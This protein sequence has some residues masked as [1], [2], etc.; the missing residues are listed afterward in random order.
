M[1]GFILINVYSKNEEYLYQAKR[2]QEEFAIKGVSV[3]IIEGGNFLLYIE[4][5]NIESKINEYDF[6]V[7]WDKDKYLL[8]ML[9]KINMPTFNSCDA[10]LTCSDKMLTHIALANKGIPMP[11]TYAGLLCYNKEQDIKPETL[12]F[13]ETL[14]YPLVVKDSYGALGKGVYLAKNRE[15][16]YS[17]MNLVK[18]RAHLFQE[19][20]ETSYGRDVRVI[21]IGN[22]VVGGM[23]RKGNN[24]FRSNVGVGGLGEPFSLTEEMKQL[25]LKVVNI[26]GLDYCGMDMLFGE[27]GPI[28][29]EVNSNAFFHMFEKVTKINVAQKYVQYIL[30]KMKKN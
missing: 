6:C 10:I 9:E 16:L 11:K 4:N 18:Y 27:N 3:D 8:K 29:C 22:E 24:D 17:L 25:A 13:L 26:L 1:K 15:E 23:L 7:F 19:Y 2:M 5:N 20:V 14:G 30:N 28:I 21:V 12:D